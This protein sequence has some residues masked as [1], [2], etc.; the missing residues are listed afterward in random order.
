M[1]NIF[2]LQKIISGGQSG[3]D[4]AALDAALAQ[5]FPLGGTC[6][7][8]R[9]AEDGP[10]ANIYPLMEFGHYRQ[11]TR[12]NIQDADGTVIFYPKYLEGGSQTTLLFCTKEKKPYQL[13]DTS[14]IHTINAVHALQ[15]FIVDKNIAILNIAGA[16]ASKAP[17]IYNYVY[18]TINMLIKNNNQFIN[19]KNI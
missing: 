19:D 2:P 16:R 15:Q 6:P 4:R 8:G 7:I 14:L 5:N 1:T 11:R 12:K 10:L 9:L 13:I 17:E 3:A 18:Q